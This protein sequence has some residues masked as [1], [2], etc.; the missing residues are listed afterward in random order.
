MFGIA[1]PHISFTIHQ[2]AQNQQLEK[3]LMEAFLNLFQKQEEESVFQSRILRNYLTRFTVC[4]MLM[5]IL[6]P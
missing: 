5:L 6:N 4:V 2:I 1:F 3:K